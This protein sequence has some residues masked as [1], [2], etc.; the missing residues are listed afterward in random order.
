MKVDPSAVDV[1]EAARAA[2]LGEIVPALP[3]G[4]RYVAL[5]AA[6][7][8]SI[9]ARELAAPQTAHDE[10]ARLASLLPAW[11]RTGDDEAD[12]RTGTAL[13]AA[14]IRTGDFA[15]GEARIRL[16]AHLLATTRARLAVSNPR[17]MARD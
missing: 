3:A 16:L 15:E 5:M 9:A 17:A 12:L 1:L 7:A 11:V 6:N 8:M 10:L 4:Y 13:L 2:I 14:R